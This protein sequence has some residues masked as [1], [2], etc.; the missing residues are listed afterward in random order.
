MKCI[1]PS[2]TPSASPGPSKQGG[3]SRWEFDSEVATYGCW[4]RNDPTFTEPRWPAIAIWTFSGLLLG[5]AFTIVVGFFPVPLVIGALIGWAV[6]LFM[7]RVKY[8]P[9]DD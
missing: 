4:M 7:T 1:I 5:L 2:D 3:R 9:E 8:T 6:G